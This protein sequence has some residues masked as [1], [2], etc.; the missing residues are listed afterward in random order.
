MCEPRG[1]PNKGK[2]PRALNAFLRREAI[3][4]VKGG[5]MSEKRLLS[6]REVA[7]ELRLNYKTVLNYRNQMAEYLPGLSD[8]KKSLYYSECKEIISLI[9]ALREDGY[10]FT[11]IREL[12]QQKR[13]IGDDPQM[14]AW[15][16][17]VIRLVRRQIRTDEDRPAQTVTD[18][19]GS[20]H[21]HPDQRV[22]AKAGMDKI[23][24]GDTYPHQSGHS[25]PGKGKDGSDHAGPDPDE[26]VWT[27]MDADGSACPN[28][29]MYEPVCSGICASGRVCSGENMAHS[30]VLHRYLEKLSAEVG[31]YLEKVVTDI[32]TEI[33]KIHS[34]L[35]VVQENIT[36][37]DKRLRQTEEITGIVA[38]DITE[39]SPLSQEPISLPEF[40][41]SQWGI[42]S[43][44]E[45]ADSGDLDAIRQSIAGNKPDSAVILEWI[46]A[47]RIMSPSPSYG[48]LAERLNSAGIPTLSG[49]G[50]WSKDNVRN[51]V[52]RAEKKEKRG[53]LG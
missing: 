41:L 12:F 5:I 4:T 17:E 38:E 24:Q 42:D 9:D 48:E 27:N 10:T 45:D 13:S 50:S 11:M 46:R 25:Y 16:Q 14:D 53:E 31:S 36:V 28:P 47:N 19:D 15:V 49:K 43:K 32:N 18:Q 33:E 7:G 22:L 29:D 37:L 44:G 26:P 1:K 52:M 35:G 6:L 34:A 8:D 3:F 30:A 23:S 51:L 39:S 40:N 20:G 2:T 21:T